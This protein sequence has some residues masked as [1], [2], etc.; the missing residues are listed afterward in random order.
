MP[1]L[2][3]P[4]TVYSSRKEL[5]F[6]N[7]DTGIQVATAGGDSISRGETFTGRTFI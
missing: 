6:S 1:D 2:L 4:A 5:V 3:K 7:L